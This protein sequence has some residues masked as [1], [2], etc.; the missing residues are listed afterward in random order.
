M[1]NINAKLNFTMIDENGNFVKQHNN[2]DTL[3]NEIDA[4]MSNN[5]VMETSEFIEWQNADVLN[6]LETENDYNNSLDTIN[7]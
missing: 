6:K 2:S 4:T 3:Q 5:F 7:V 1:K